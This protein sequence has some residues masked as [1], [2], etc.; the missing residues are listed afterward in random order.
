MVKRK[1]EVSLKRKS[2]STLFKK[3]KF[4]EN[5]LMK[6]YGEKTS[7]TYIQSNSNANSSTVAPL[8]KPPVVHTGQQ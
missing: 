8:A 5:I 1:H 2:G 6:I 3:R 7:N 4:R